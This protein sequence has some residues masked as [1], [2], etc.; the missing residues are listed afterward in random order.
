MEQGPLG[1][2]FPQHGPT[3]KEQ[4]PVPTTLINSGKYKRFPYAT[5]PGKPRLGIQ[6]ESSTP[7]D[8]YIVQF[9]DMDE[10]RMSEDYDAISFQHTEV[11]DAQITIP[12]GFQHDWWLILENTAEKAAAVHYQLFDL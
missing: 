6:V 4:I 1:P 12:K 10:W 5:T 2:T 11:V 8:V 7:I 3:V 9:S